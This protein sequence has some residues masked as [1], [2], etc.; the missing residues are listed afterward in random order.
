MTITRIL[1]AALLGAILCA[2]AEPQG[3]CTRYRTYAFSGN[4][5]SLAQGPGGDPSWQNGLANAQAMYGGTG[6]N[7]TQT[8]VGDIYPP[9]YAHWYG[10]CESYGY[11]CS[12]DPTPPP[13]GPSETG[14][15][16]SCK[17]ST[18][19]PQCGSPI[20]LASGNTF[21]TQTDLTLPGLGG[22]L[23]LTR[24]WNS[25]WPSSQSA[26]SVGFFGNNW[27]STYEERVFVGSDGTMKYA[28]SDGSFWSFLLYG[29]PAAYKV[30]AP[31]GTPATLTEQ[32][33]TSW[34]IVFQNGEK[35]VFNYNSGSLIS[36]TDRNGNVTQLS[37]DATN[38]LTTVTDPASRHLYFGY[39]SGSSRLVASVTSD[40]GMSLSYAYDTQGRLTT[41]TKLDLTTITFQYDS[42]SRI[43]S[44]LD[45]NGKV[46]E[47]HTYDTFGRGLTSAQANGV[48]S[49]SVSYQ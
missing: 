44:V 39:G 8:L 1:M 38:R 34:T 21:I 2:H 46:L 49:V 14:S 4:S 7:C 15:G 48:N 20:N 25:I 13:S 5:G 24:T 29:S 19:A 3:N 10:Y 23:S 11:T 12:A 17:T 42:G 40:F 27:R 9:D 47:S 45:S 33:T 37:Y 28:R 41:V 22:G 6:P 18:P 31:A 26:S 36:I 32:G 30:I 43:T 16:S 35:R